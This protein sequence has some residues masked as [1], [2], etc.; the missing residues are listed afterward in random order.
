MFLTEDEK[1]IISELRARQIRDPQ[2]V[3]SYC[4]IGNF[5]EPENLAAVRSLIK[6]S[7][8]KVKFDWGKH[9]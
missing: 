6:S 4:I 7:Q 1:I 8:K 9:L 5:N 2:K 3:I